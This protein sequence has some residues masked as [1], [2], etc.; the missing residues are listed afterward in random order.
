MSIE[1]NVSKLQE[2]LRS[3]DKPIFMSHD[4]EED[5]LRQ[6][7]ILHNIIGDGPL[8]KALGELFTHAQDNVMAMRESCQQINSRIDKTIKELRS[9]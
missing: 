1:G 4:I 6:L 3:L 9:L 2:C 8:Y 5:L 7:Q